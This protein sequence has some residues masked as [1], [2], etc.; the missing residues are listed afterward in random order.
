MIGPL[1]VRPLLPSSLDPCLTVLRLV[2]TETEDLSFSSPLFPKP[3]LGSQVWEA[4]PDSFG[5]CSRFELRFIYLQTLPPSFRSIRYRRAAQTSQAFQPYLSSYHF[6]L[7]VLC[8]LPAGWRTESSSHFPPRQLS[9]SSSTPSRRGFLSVPKM[10]EALDVA[11][12][13]HSLVPR[14]PCASSEG[15]RSAR[16]PRRTPQLS[17][18]SQCCSY[19][20]QWTQFI[21]I[22]WLFPCC[23]HED[24]S[25]T[26]TPAS[27]C[28]KL[29]VCINNQMYKTSPEV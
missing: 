22:T 2:L 5:G 20:Q 28:L 10:K 9:S 29:S 17:P 13:S 11:Q 21:I 3:M 26:A 23:L 25:Y 27:Q 1:S 8:R 14:F 12:A 15:R 24:R 16:C 18:V 6:H 7:K 4:M 19:A